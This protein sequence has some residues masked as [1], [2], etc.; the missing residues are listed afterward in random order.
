MRRTLLAAALASLMA[1]AL[2]P[3]G[4]PV[5]AQGDGPAPEVRIDAWINGDGRTAL[6]D[7]RGDVVLLE[8]WQTH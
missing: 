6:T 8:F 1:L 3:G 2:P 4:D 7:Y 5:L